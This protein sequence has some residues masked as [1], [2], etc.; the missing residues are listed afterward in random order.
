MKETDA[1]SILQ[2]T[3]RNSIFTGLGA[4]STFI[5]GFVF[6]G[7]TIRYLGESRAGYLLA[8][9]AVIALNALVGGF[10]LGT[11]SVRR[12]AFL[13]AQGD[14]V[15]A[16]AVVGSVSTVNIITG[17]LFSLLIVILFP[18]IF[19]WSRLEYI[20][21]EDAL[22]AT[23]FI[24]GSFLLTQIMSS[25]RAVYEGLQRYDLITAL[26]TAFSLLSGTCGIVVLAIAPTMR[27]IA[28]T[29]FAVN[30]IRLACDAYF[31]QRLLKRLPPL[32][33]MW[34]EI[35]PM[36]GFGGWTY[37]S[38][39]GGFL[40]T[41]MDRLILT[42]FLGS[43]A[44]PYYA[45]PQRLYSQI[46]TALINQY[47]FVFPMLSAF[48]DKATIQIERVEDRLRWFVGLVS[49]AAYT[50]LFLIGPPILGL[51]VSPE[52]ARQA[53]LPLVLACVQGF[54]HAQMVVPYFNSWAVGSGA[55]NAAAQLLNGTLVG[56][57]SILLVPRFGFVGA[58]IAQ[59]W[60]G[61][62]VIG[63]SLWVRHIISPRSHIWG[64]PSAYL[65]PFLMSLVWL[66]IVEMGTRLV[67]SSPSMF[68]ALVLLGVIVGL[69]VV[70]LVERLIFSAYDR[71]TTLIRAMAIPLRWLRGLVIAG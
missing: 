13:H 28:V 16:R 41:N 34:S 25:W 38:S 40:F 18:T 42:T 29:G 3:V 50:G 51:L 12:L 66:F 64:W 4:V 23:L 62:I 43:A 24:S 61:V 26:A 1:S 14:F 5:L 59:L 63:H 20:Y 70:R 60:I 9:Q 39:L 21:K 35:R 36:L 44:L 53:T 27:A 52:F 31:V 68:Y 19:A 48:G 58:S 17:L 46:H 54:F 37:L 7:L 56:L 65:S 2:R 71:W 33:W 45:I 15:K 30:V 10:G 69:W 22:W 8:L 6:A 47:Q 67:P 11:A 49:G 32:T 55:P 57:T